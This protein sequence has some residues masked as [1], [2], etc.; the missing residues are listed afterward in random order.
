[1]I[2]YIRITEGTIGIIDISGTISDT[3]AYDFEGDINDL[4]INSYNYIDDGNGNIIHV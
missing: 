1:M 2:V 4:M 3:T